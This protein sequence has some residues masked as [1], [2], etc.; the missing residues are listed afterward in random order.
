METS[1]SLIIRLDD[2]SISIWTSFLKVDSIT[3]YCLAIWNKEKWVRE[4]FKKRYHQFCFMVVYKEEQILPC[5]SLSTVCLLNRAWPW[6]MSKIRWVL[7][8]VPSKMNA[9]S[10]FSKSISIFTTPNDFSLGW[11]PVMK[12]TLEPLL[13]WVSLSRIVKYRKTLSKLNPMEA[14]SYFTPSIKNKV[15]SNFPNKWNH[16]FNHFYV[17]LFRL[18]FN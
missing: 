10:S 7:F 6:S 12:P 8:Y 11:I 13:T 4:A 3:F 2:I 9:T 15:Q 1:I 17:N 5:L 16:N 18:R 14:S